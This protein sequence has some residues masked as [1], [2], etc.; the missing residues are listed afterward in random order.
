MCHLISLL[1]HVPAEYPRDFPLPSA[2]TDLLKV[3]VE[4]IDL[5]TKVWLRVDPATVHLPSMV[6]SVVSCP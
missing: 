4:Y 3:Y 2:S 5:E 6:S 1:Q